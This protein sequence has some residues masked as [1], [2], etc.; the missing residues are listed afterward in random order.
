M[1]DGW[2]IPSKSDFEALISTVDGSA[3][4]LKAAP[5]S[6]TTNWPLS[7]WNGTDDYGFT[8]LPH[9]DYTNGFYNLNSY[10]NY[11]STTFDFK[12]Y[13]FNICCSYDSNAVMI[14]ESHRYSGF[15]IRLVKNLDD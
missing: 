5:G 4:K 14:G 1:P 11:W 9:G 2:R 7:D 12:D 10:G 3:I 15:G 8:A 13:Y 6:I